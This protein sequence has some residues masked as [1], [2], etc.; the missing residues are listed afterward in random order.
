M[1][2]YVEHQ[3]K[4][5][6]GKFVKS[7]V[8]II[9]FIILFIVFILLFGYAFMWLWNWLMPDIFGLT[10]LTYWQ[11][12]GLLILAKLVFGGFEG[13][14][15]GKKS[16]KSKGRCAPGE[17]WDSKSDF[18]KWKHYDGFWR[19]EG[20]KA[21]HDYVERKMNGNKKSPESREGES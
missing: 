11:A 16:K 10:T 2:K 1:E 13:Q 19:E 5:R 18:S 15:P 3:V 7:A 21:Y 12:I 14:G 4:S 17:R 20:E 8:K 9:F 6:V